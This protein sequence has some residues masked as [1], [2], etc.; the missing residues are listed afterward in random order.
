[1][2]FAMASSALVLIVLMAAGCGSAP[3]E[4]AVEG[5]PPEATTPEVPPEALAKARQA[6]DALT[7]ELVATLG[8][9]LGAGGPVG[10]VKVCSEM[11]PEIAAAHSGDG[12]TVRRVTLKVR[13]PIDT[14]DDYERRVLQDLEAKLVEGALPPEVAEVVSD[15]AGSR[16][17]YL[18]PLVI[19]TP[20]LSCHGDVESMKPELKSILE[21]RYP[22]DQA[23]GY[24]EG[25]LRGAVSV[26]VDL[27]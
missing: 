15:D 2:R 7:G 20:C 5:S 1:M 18:R 24:E 4:P 14:P 19:K 16:L 11:A 6:A 10:A 21:D 22:D 8:R 23:V 9:E 25:D 26:T 12:V 3:E 17:R 13:N 27:S